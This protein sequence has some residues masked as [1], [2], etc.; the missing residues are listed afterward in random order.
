[1]ALT[2]EQRGQLQNDMQEL[3]F[4][5]RP[6]LVGNYMQRV[7]LI[8]LLFGYTR[9]PYSQCYLHEWYGSPKEVLDLLRELVPHSPEEVDAWA[10]PEDVGAWKKSPGVA[11]AVH[12]D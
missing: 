4:R 1:M 2:H 9:N 7:E 3:L 5:I 10:K 6:I 8:G 11:T 12:A